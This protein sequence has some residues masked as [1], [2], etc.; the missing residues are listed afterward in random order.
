[1]KIIKDKCYEEERALYDSENLCLI[2]CKFDGEADGE[3]ALKESNNILAEDCYFNLRYPFWHN[4]QLTIAGGEM[5]EKCRAPIWYSKNIQIEKIN[6]YGT[7]AIRECRNVRIFDSTITSDEFGWSTDTAKLRRLTVKGEY[8]ML[9]AKNLDIKEITFSGKYSLQYIE[10]AIIEDCTLNTKDAL[11]HA[12]N[13][14]IKN[15]TIR[16]E[17]L[18]W[19]S[20]NITLEN[21]TIIGTQPLCYCKGLVMKNCEMYECD[22]AFEKSEVDAVI[23]TPVISI[24]N[25]KSGKI[26]VP[27]YKELINSDPEAKCEIILKA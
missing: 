19:Y 2:N 16:G 1:M 3:S 20:E 22:L 27:F 15:C 12:K 18:G 4:D 13:V 9:R 26:V 21:C 7:K 14:T 17:Y 25:A 11:W 6:L 23:L 8:F 5:T 10:N 24:K